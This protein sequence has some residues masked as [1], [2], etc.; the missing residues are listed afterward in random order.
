MS[1]TLSKKKESSSSKVSLSDR[2][3]EATS[4]AATSS[5]SLGGV[6]K[7]RF[8][9]WPEWNDAEVNKEKW[10]SSKGAEDGKTTKSPTAP[11]FEDPEGKICLPPSL[12]VH[13][14]KRPTEF[15]V[16]KAPTVVENQTTFDLMSSNDHLICSE[17]MRWI[18]SE[19]YIV[20]MLCN[21]GGTEQDGWRPWEHIYSL[22]KVV[23]GH[24]P[25]YNNYGKYVV[26]LYWMGFWRKI[27]I[28]DSMPFDEEN[29]LLLPAS[30]CQSELWPMLLAKALIKVANT[31]V[32]SEVCGEIGEFTFIHTLTGWIPEISP[33]KPVYLGKVWDFLRDSIPIFTHPD[34]SLPETKP[35]TADPAAGRDSSLNDSKSKLPE[36]E[37]SKGTPEVA[38]CA[39]Y[40]P[41]QLHN[42]SSGFGLM[43]NSSELLRRYGLSSLYSHIV[44]LTRTRACPLEAP[45][46]PPPVP[47]WKLIRQRKEIV[48]TD[49]PRKL[50]LSKPEQFIEVASP[51]LSY[52]VKSSV[53]PIPELKVKSEAKQSA[54]K[55]Q[56]Y[57]SPMVSIAE[58]EETECREGFE[59]DAA[60]RTTNSANSTDKIEVTAEDRKKDDDDISS[61]RPKTA[62][63]EPVTEEPSAPIKPILQ[64]TWVDLHDFAKCFHTLLVFHKPQ[65]YPH[66]F[67]KSHLKSTVLPKTATGINC[68]GSSSQSLTTGS[69]H[70]SSAVASPKCSEVRGT[71]YM[72]VD[73]LQ[74]SKILISFSA[75]LLWGET[76][77]EKK[78]MSAACRSAVL[79]VQPYSW[80]NLQ[81]R[82][83][84]LTIKTTSSKAV[85]LSLPSGRHVLSLHTKAAL[86]Y[87][88]HICSK[89]P[90]IFGDEE[91]IMSHLAKE[92]ARFTEQS[93]SI[94]KALSREVAVF[95]DVQDQP[96]ARRA[97]EEAFCPNNIS[98]TLGKWE[99]HKVF[100]S[101]VYHMLCE[102]LGR[103][104]TA[105]ERF[106]VLAVTAD[107]SL[108][109]NEP[110]EHSPA[111][112][113]HIRVYTEL[114]APESWKDRQPTAKEIKAVTI[115]Q[116]G[117]KGHLVRKILNASKPG[118]KE[119]L[120]ASKILFDMWPKVESNADKHAAFLLRYIIDHSERK[121]ELYPCQQDESTRIT[122]SDYSVSLQDT[123]N[124]WVLVFREVFLVPKEMLLVPKVYSPIPNCLLHVI[125][126][127]TGEELDMVFNKV[128]PHV[129]QPNKLGYTFVA[130]AITPESPPAGTKWRMRL[131]GSKEP[132]P[133][134]ACETPLNTFSVKE[135]WDY[136]VP[137]DKDF[138][139]RYSVQVTA[140]VLGTVQFQTS[141]PDVLI[142]LSI[143]DQEKE[144]AS[145]TGTGHVIIPV[146]YF[147][148]NKAEENQ[149]GG[150]TQ[151]KGVKMVNAPQQSAAGKSDSSSDQYQPPT[152]TMGHK[153][154]VKAE[155]LYK[156][157]DLDE[158]QLAFVH[159]LRDL[160]KNEMKVYKPEDLKCSSTTPSND[161][162]KSDTP[163]ANRKGESDKEKWKPAAS[164][165]SGSR[166][167]T[168]LDLTKA[169]WTLR[170][171]SDKSRAES[172]VVKKDTERIE[173]IKAIKKAWEMAEPGR[174]A[175]AFQSRLKFLN[176]DQHQAS[177]EATTADAESRE[178]A[179]SRPGPDTSLS[180][181][182]QKLTDTSSSYPHMDYTPFIRRQKD[183]PAL[184]DSQIEEVQ[185]RERLEK[186]Q[187]FR[188]VRDNVLEH[189]KQQEL[190]G[191]ELM[192]RQLEMY[193]NMQAA[194][195]QHRKK[196]LDA[197]EAFSSRQMAAMKKEQ[198]EKQ[199]LEDTQQAAQEK[200]IST[201]PANRQPNKHAKSAGKK[202]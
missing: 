21:S 175:K 36:P 165:K 107:P 68:T 121:A 69:L 191:M 88:V 37:K 76:A 40:Y 20:W 116:A 123:A 122:F 150:P 128:V 62:L 63:K 92:S 166:L 24:V 79:L 156:S 26:R 72:C 93:L 57:G 188:L 99:L 29:N 82:L 147:L 130:E 190:N 96:A 98:T 162:H 15:I 135:F 169:N 17:L 170:V 39:S 16:N 27:T 23:K 126:N 199:A 112:R 120:S 152:E 117:F 105:E 47:R 74:P 70:V 101:A 106:A 54:H 33:I 173:Q 114:K 103:K 198:E 43:A 25:L 89:T 108:L 179:A 157:W 111:C 136:Y 200:T 140:D 160:E 87:H 176:Q 53:D 164:S 155:V 124:S 19:I 94:L 3:T 73:S 137:I 194:L 34:E 163:K 138:I 146:F 159:M 144:V 115:L 66:H 64:E 13:S 48:V 131:I 151:D 183:F 141:K 143:L 56:C 148:A 142:R 113:S 42:N 186:I 35:Q 11:F 51:F 91:T 60:E 185:Q 2:Q 6:W 44:L 196:F 31:N 158:S 52:R 172:I 177:D 195:W 182:K 75:L 167:G 193:E 9:I 171:V 80:K 133:K 32:V 129:Y 119:N 118:T 84:V 38:V 180:T 202:K 65:E 22:C 50:P 1:K 45:P 110:K 46:K 61:D 5:E 59:P 187:T 49:E 41:F 197:C 28:D 168:S 14:W 134:L 97:L 86:G 58:K 174:C 67:Q 181:S 78:E 153:Y 132:L 8:P 145:N 154:V 12:R 178:S 125:N 85:M 192:R 139:C 127:D 184:M 149:K 77:E 95:S 4:L 10:D 81:S 104:L 90:F 102:V 161:G 201:S 55:K 30:T 189:R 71:H 7:C 100:N 83:P 109:V 18:I